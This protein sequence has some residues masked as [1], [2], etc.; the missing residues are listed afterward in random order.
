[1]T[2]GE[3]LGDENPDDR[4]LT[5]R[6]RCDERENTN[7]HDRKTLGKEGPRHQAK[8]SDVAERAD[9]QERSSAKP[10]NQPKADEGKDQIGD[11]DADRLQQCGVRTQTSQF[12]YPR[13]EIENRI[14]AGKLVEEGNE[15]SEQNWF[16]QAAR[17]EMSRRRLFG[18]SSDNLIRLRF[19]LGV[20]S[21]GLD[22]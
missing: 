16:A 11:A 6:M 22:L 8:R 19:D 7:R 10:V 21:V 2:I 20:G 14:D 4:A 17:P 12:K 1:M 5:N 3:Y 18:R 13:R 15:D 9:N